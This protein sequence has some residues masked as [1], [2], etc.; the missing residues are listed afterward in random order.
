MHAQF[1]LPA[2]PHY[3]RA[4]HAYL[5]VRAAVNR[6]QNPK[7][8]NA[9]QRSLVGITIVTCAVGGLKSNKRA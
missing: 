6:L 7:A 8:S 2:I 9:I 1:W 4:V 5:R 3:N